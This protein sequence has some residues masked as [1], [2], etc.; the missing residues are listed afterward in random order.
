MGGWE[1]ELGGIPSA[2]AANESRRAGDEIA[3]LVAGFTDN[4][5]GFLYRRVNNSP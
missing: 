1:R 4:Y 2:N 5:A 3:A